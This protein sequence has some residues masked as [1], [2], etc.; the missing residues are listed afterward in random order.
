MTRFAQVDLNAVA[1]L[2]PGDKVAARVA[3]RGEHFDFTPSNGKVHSDV[4]L[5]ARAP[6]AAEML[7]PTFVDLTGTTIGRLKVTGIAVDITS[8][9]TNWVVRCVCGAY[10]TRKARYIKTC[11]SGNNPGQ[12]EPM[13][14][15]CTKTRKLQK[16]F[17]VV[18]NGP[19]VKIEGYK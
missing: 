13:C 8:N 17:G 10:E 19:L 16:G 15:W 3:G 1:P 11:A 5:R 4:P 2:L 7:M 18:R 6:S 9:G 12:E 14:D